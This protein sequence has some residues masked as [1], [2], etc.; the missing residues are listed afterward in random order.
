[1]IEKSFR[2]VVGSF[3]VSVSTLLTSSIYGPLFAIG[4]LLLVSHL[5]SRACFMSYLVRSN[6]LFSKGP[7]L[8]LRV[9]ILGEQFTQQENESEPVEF[10]TKDGLTLRGSF[11]HRNSPVDRG[12]VLFFHELNGDR[13]SVLPYLEN[14]RKE[15]FNL[16]TFDQRGHG[17]S[18]CSAETHPVPWVTANDL[19][20][21]TAAAEYL[22]NRTNEQLGVFGLGKGATLAL[23]CA[24]RNSQVQ[25]VVMDSP[26]PE[27]QLYEKNC[28]TAF[29]KLGTHFATHHF[30][31]FVALSVK[32]LLYLIA[33]PFFSLLSAWRRFMFRLWYGGNFVNTWPII[34]KLRKPILILHGGLDSCV[35]LP[36]IH[37]FCRRMPVQPRICLPGFS[38]E[39]VASFF[40][41]TL[42]SSEPL[43]TSNPDQSMSACPASPQS[44]VLVK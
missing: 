3:V 34:K 30:L 20:D 15:G 23:C 13:W 44:F 40:Q 36:Q 8:P 38:A 1:V 11:F 5:V 42:N 10:S 6:R 29:E 19:E 12:T 27:D 2:F 25:A 43:R 26:A 9:R 24:S 39:H 18:D 35:T 41:Q 4:V 7:W 22:H 31:K 28:L 32:T 14:L 33:C 16:F 17:E 21:L 37:A